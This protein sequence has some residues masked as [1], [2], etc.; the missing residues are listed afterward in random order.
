MTD[1]EKSGQDSEKPVSYHSCPSCGLPFNTAIVVCPNDG[2]VIKTNQS[3]RNSLLTRYEFL[4]EA[5]S[6]GAGVVYK[7]KQK[8]TGKLV[9]IKMVSLDQVNKESQ[10][11]FQAE[12]N[13]C[14]RLVHDHLIKLIDYGIAESGQPY[15]ILEYVDG[16]DLSELLKKAGGISLR[17]S[18]EIA[19]Q[20]VSGL[21]HAHAQD[22]LHR[23]LKPGNIMI[24]WN[25]GHPFVKIVDFS[26][27]K[28]GEERPTPAAE[29]MK[30]AEE[31]AYG[32]SQRSITPLDPVREI[33]GTPAYMSPEQILGKEL[34]QRSDLYSFGCVLYQMLV[35]SPPYQGT[36]SVQTVYK[37]LNEEAPALSAAAHGRS[38]PPGIEAIVAKLLKKD[39]AQRYKTAGDLLDDLMRE[40]A[41]LIE[42]EK[43][44]PVRKK[45]E[46]K[47]Y[48]VGQKS[49]SGGLIIAAIVLVCIGAFC[50]F[51][52]AWKAEEVEKSTQVSAK[53]G[54]KK[55]NTHKQTKKL[56]QTG[57]PNSATSPAST[58]PSAVAPAS[59]P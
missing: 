55:I 34:D 48:N 33:V 5:G 53:S 6:G 25:A 4:S 22:I 8:S 11:R 39:P 3:L 9:A 26:I 38:F 17:T 35:G 28:L 43:Q 1:V 41:L 30:Y 21:Q 23:D 58:A 56:K 47:Q 10:A 32:V 45:A 36:N 19:E 42:K 52:L 59:S 16:I 57:L 27:A 18:L 51:Y 29:L 24:T 31:K 37:Q 40:H 2:T 15:I 12:A 14:S 50:A 7:A 49:F 54:Q 13:A 44:G 46:V 20:L